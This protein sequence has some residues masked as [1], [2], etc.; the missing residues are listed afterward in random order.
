MDVIQLNHVTKTIGDFTLGPID[1]AIPSGSICAIVGDNGAGKSTL[2]KMIMGLAKETEGEVFLFGKKRDLSEEGWRKRIA[3]QSQTLKGIDR[4]TGKDLTQLISR[5]SVRF[6]HAA[7]K[8]YAEDLD[9][10]LNKP[11]VN[12]SEGLQKKL[13]VAL[14][15]AQQAEL[16]IFDEPSAH[17]D[18]MAQRYVMD[19]M[20][21]QMEEN[22]N[23]TILIAS[24]QMDD[25]RKLADYI[26]IIRKG[27]FLGLFE[28]DELISRFVRYWVNRAVPESIEGVVKK[29]QQGQELISI[30]EHD[31][32]QSLQRLGITILQKSNIEIDDIIPWILS[33][34]IK[35]EPR[36]TSFIR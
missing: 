23:K 19:E 22:P 24:H 12:L 25:I 30:N 27:K 11:I 4:F 21:K 10:S 7:F 9:L 13:N 3:Y 15:L 20:I 5:F 29:Q 2:I 32:E 18:L 1:A 31:T 8:R 34:E 26:M 6:N 28:K 36:E 33:D 14:T 17:M 35:L 16:L